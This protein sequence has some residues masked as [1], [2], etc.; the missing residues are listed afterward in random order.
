[1][2][3]FLLGVP[4]KLKAISDYLTTH[5]TSTR[6]AKLD[7]L[8]GNAALASDW[9]STRAAKVDNL[10]GALSGRLGSIRSI[11]TG[12]ITLTS[13][14]PGAQSVTAT[15]TS[16]TTSRAVCLFGGARCDNND[17]TACSVN[18]SL[19]NATTVTASRSNGSGTAI[20]AYTVIEFN[21]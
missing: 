20:A 11:Q 1:M 5:W 6:A 12:F 18:L 14:G 2:I 4:G 16:V 10:D 8:T 19:T 9:T 17:A 15:I 3:D 21:A 7:Y 13:V